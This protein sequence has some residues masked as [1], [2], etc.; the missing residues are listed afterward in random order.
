MVGSRDWGF[1]IRDWGK[2]SGIG[3]R[4][5]GIG[6]RE[7]GIGNRKEHDAIGLQS[8]EARLLLLLVIP[9]KA[10]SASFRRSRTSR[11]FRVMPG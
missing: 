8:D 3:N 10:G 6:N 11:D 1:G 5:S 9:A 4:E 2:A 7:S